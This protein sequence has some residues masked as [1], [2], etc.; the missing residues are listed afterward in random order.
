MIK[1]DLK[2]KLLSSE[3]V[4]I[5]SIEAE[6]PE[7]EFVTLFGKSGAGKTSILRMIA[8]LFQPDEGCIEVNGETWF[9][10]RKKINIPPQRRNC[11][12]VF[13]DYSLFPNMSVRENVEF[14][15]DKT[16]DRKMVDDLLCLVDMAEFADSKPSILSGGQKQRIALVRAI[17]RRP[18]I[19]L[20]D[21]PLASIDPQMR[22]KLQDDI[23]SIHRNF[24][25]TS[26]IVSHDLS[27]VF[28]M[29]SSV[30]V[31]ENGKISRHGR[32]HDIFME[33]RI[34]GKFKFTGEV[35]EV[36]KNDTLYTITVLIGNSIVRVT[37]LEEDTEGL[38]PGS[39]V[40]VASKAFNPIIVK[41][42]V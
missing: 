27:E 31:L 42:L 28:R 34:S 14:A 1:L 17:A 40:I 37:A 7:M 18:K 2:K 3:G 32:P 10:S 23:I 20:L 4:M 38:F 35:L 30:L 11:G 39:K 13:Q 16:Q 6:I 21:E 15:F 25:I 19:L 8:G 29:S 12:M 22:L 24:S 41:A 9:N 26:I 36:K 33:N 5:L